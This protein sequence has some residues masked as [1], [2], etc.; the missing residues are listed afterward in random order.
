MF[1]TMEETTN[2]NFPEYQFA[3][4]IL[5]TTEN[6]YEKQKQHT[7]KQWSM[8]NEKMNLFLKNNLSAPYY[9]I[10]HKV[11]EFYTV[12]YGCQIL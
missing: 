5:H 11:S 3:I 4:L 2:I 9:I 12:F 6:N 10:Y 8:L 1:W 7:M